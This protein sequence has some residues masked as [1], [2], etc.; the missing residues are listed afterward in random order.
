MHTRLTARH[1]TLLEGTPAGRTASTLG[2]PAGA[3]ALQRDLG[4]DDDL[5]SSS[6]FERAG[7]STQRKRETK[8]V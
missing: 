2:R 3:D 8:N 7:S 5:C 6:E 1:R 4:V